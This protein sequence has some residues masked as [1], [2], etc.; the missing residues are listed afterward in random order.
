MQPLALA[1]VT[2]VKANTTAEHLIIARIFAPKLEDSSR[3]TI[4]FAPKLEDSSRATIN[5]AGH[6]YVRINAVLAIR[7]ADR[8]GLCVARGYCFIGR[9][10]VVGRLGKWRVKALILT[11]V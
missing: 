9:I 10:C 4:N 2:A 3:A 5:K 8:L 11:T 1:G 7:I 6:D